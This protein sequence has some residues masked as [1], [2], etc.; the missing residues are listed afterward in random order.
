MN[1]NN[2]GNSSLYL[3]IAGLGL[4][5]L[6]AG[7]WGAF[8][9]GKDVGSTLTYSAALSRIETYNY[10]ADISSDLEDIAS[11]TGHGLYA[12]ASYNPPPL[13][14]ASS[15]YASTTITVTGAAVGDF[16]IAS[17]GSVTSTDQWALSAKVSAADTVSVTFAYVASSTASLDLTGETLRVRVFRLGNIT[18]L[19]ATTT[20][21]NR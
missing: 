11:S 10:L 14:I 9:A 17:F 3:V 13:A 4:A 18:L 1:N 15:T 7:G 16:A 21:A 5:L 8:N 19:T 2:K 12:T 20:A 6:L